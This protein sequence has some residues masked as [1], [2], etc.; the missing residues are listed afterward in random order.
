MSKETN[1]TQEIAVD[2]VQGAVSAINKQLAVEITRCGFDLDLVRKGKQVLTRTV[3]RSE[4]DPRYVGETF[5]IS[6][7]KIP[8]RI[9]MCVKWSPKGF[10]IEVNSDAVANAIKANKNF[11][12][13]KGHSPV[14]VG[15]VTQ[16]EIDVEALANKYMK[17]YEEDAKKESLIKC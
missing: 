4:T 11:G 6:G 8:E 7:K 12:I 3:K 5:S 2:F 14:F 16:N 13:K 15:Q 9:I 10:Q 17:K 1:T